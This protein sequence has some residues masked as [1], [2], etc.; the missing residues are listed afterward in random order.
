MIHMPGRPKNRARLKAEATRF[1]ESE[2]MK[3]GGNAFRVTA[4]RLWRV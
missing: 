3:R 4:P 1:T 2:K